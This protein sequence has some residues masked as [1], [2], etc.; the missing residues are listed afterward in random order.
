LE[1]QELQGP[2]IGD[3][4][5]YLTN[6]F[7]ASIN[8]GALVLFKTADGRYFTISDFAPLPDFMLSA[9]VEE[10]EYEPAIPEPTTLLLVGLGLIGI[11]GLVRRRK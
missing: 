7:E 4:G 9:T 6:P 3:P 11:M 1:I 10:Y 8:S 2:L 5:D